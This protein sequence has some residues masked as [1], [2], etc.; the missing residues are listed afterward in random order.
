MLGIRESNSELERGA[1]EQNSTLDGHVPCIIVQTE[2]GRPAVGL[3]YHEAQA[4]QSEGLE[5]Q[6]TL[7]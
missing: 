7:T 3:R 6:T 5:V 4:L 2:S 1:L